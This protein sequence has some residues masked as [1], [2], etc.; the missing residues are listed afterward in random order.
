M[1]V[2]VIMCLMYHTY[3]DECITCSQLTKY[4]T[5]G[6]SINYYQ[7]HS[8]MSSLCHGPGTRTSSQKHC[9]GKE[10]VQSMQLTLHGSPHKN[11]F[12][13]KVSTYNY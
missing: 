6:L 8:G 1:I 13:L 7:L 12:A 3:K 11:D 5:M 4:D 9:S 10:S 2:Q